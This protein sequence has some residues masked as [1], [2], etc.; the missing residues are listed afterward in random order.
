ML[1][2]MILLALIV[3]CG[4]RKIIEEVDESGNTRGH[5]ISL[6]RLPNGTYKVVD[7]SQPTI[8]G[9]IFDPMNVEESPLVEELSGKNPYAKLPPKAYDYVK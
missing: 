8:N 4:R 7:K 2:L 9:S 1:S 3:Q 6:H 5:T